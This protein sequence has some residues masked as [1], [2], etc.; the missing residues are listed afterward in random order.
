M[1]F[2]EFSRC[3][4]NDEDKNCNDKN[5]IKISRQSRRSISLHFLPLETFFVYVYVFLR[6][7]IFFQ[8]QT[9]F[10]KEKNS[11]GEGKNSRAQQLIKSRKRR[12]A[13]FEYSAGR[14]RVKKN[15][16][17]RLIS[18]WLSPRTRET[19]INV[20][21]STFVASFFPSFLSKLTLVDN[22]SLSTPGNRL[23]LP[24]T[25]ILFEYS[26]Y[27]VINFKIFDFYFI[28]TRY[29]KNLGTWS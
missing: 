22:D 11:T 3:L 28:L 26:N 17:T 14:Y 7:E 1:R 24:M 13:D 21:A 25:K 6:L 20:A 4:N 12:D 27:S 2:F 5:S 16:D 9:S 23:R 29:M 10:T 19:R 15:D 18:W 8:E